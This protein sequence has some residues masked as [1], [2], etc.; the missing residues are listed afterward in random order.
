MRP[1]KPLMLAIA[2]V[3]TL[4]S[5]WRRSIIAFVT[6]AAGAFAM[7]PF[8]LFPALMIPMTTAI[9]LIDGCA[10]IR[11][12]SRFPWMRLWLPH[13]AWR[14]FCAGW[15]WGFGYFIAGLW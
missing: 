9:W 10:D 8:D 15:W 5:G 12:T 11:Q 1:K 3:V 6:G 14:A 2:A 7:A 4:A 13:S